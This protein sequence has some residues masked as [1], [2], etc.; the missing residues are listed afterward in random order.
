MGDRAG[1][2][3]ADQRDRQDDLVDPTLA[4]LGDRVDDIG[5]D[6]HIVGQPIGDHAR[7]WPRDALARTGARGR[8][9]RRRRARPCAATGRGG[10]SAAGGVALEG[11]R[12]GSVAV[13][14]YGGGGMP[15]WPVWAKEPRRVAPGVRDV[16]LAQ[17]RHRRTPRRCR[18]T[19]RGPRA[20][21]AGS[22]PRSS[23]AGRRGRPERGLRRCRP[24]PRARDRGSQEVAPAQVRLGRQE[25]APEP[26][27]H[28]AVVVRE[29]EREIPSLSEGD[30]LVDLHVGQC[31]V[32]QGQVAH[33]HATGM[34]HHH[35]TSNTSF[36][37]AGP[38]RPAPRGR[39]RT[40]P[41]RTAGSARRRTSR[42][43]TRRRSAGSRRPSP[44][45]SGSPR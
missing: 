8:L 25:V 33:H 18:S 27:R 21:C 43:G 14:G 38:R 16:D 42:S 10:R 1:C 23:G 40:A 17:D 12:A 36:A 29:P 3:G 26:I 41:G 44:T 15:G 7:R 39:W 22:R 4:E 20:R 11:R 35:D 30:Q 32:G 19:R 2:R 9:W 5:D 31:R 34:S 45:G 24:R 37:V 13:D 6:P 28:A